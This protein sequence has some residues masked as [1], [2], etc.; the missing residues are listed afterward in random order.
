[1]GPYVILILVN[2]IIAFRLSFASHPIFT[3]N[4]ELLAKG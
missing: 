1:M 3:V 4:L 2:V